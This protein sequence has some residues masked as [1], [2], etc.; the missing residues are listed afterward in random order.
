MKNKIDDISINLNNEGKISEK[1]NEES[2]NGL[3]LK[4]NLASGDNT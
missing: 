2:N 1:S 3:H 4:D